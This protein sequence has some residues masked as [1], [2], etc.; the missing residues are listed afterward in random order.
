MA[1]TKEQ[2]IADLL[3]G[4]SG[5]KPGQLVHVL[6]EDIVLALTPDPT[7]APAPAPVNNDDPE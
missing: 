5:Q 6:A 3:Q 7:P 2:V 1:K 4:S